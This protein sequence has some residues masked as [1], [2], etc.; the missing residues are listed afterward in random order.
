MIHSSNTLTGHFIRYTLLVKG[1]TPFTYLPTFTLNKPFL[2]KFGPSWHVDIMQVL[3]ICWLLIC[4]EN[5]PVAP[6]PKGAP[7]DWVLV[8]GDRW[9]TSL[10][11][12]ELCEMLNCPAGSSHQKRVHCGH[13]GMDMVGNSLP[14][15]IPLYHRCLKSS[16]QPVWH[17]QL[18]HVQ[19]HLYP[20]SSPFCCSVLPSASCLEHVFMPKS[21]ELGPCDY[22]ISCLC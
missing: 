1:W 5:L 7:V 17:Q 20:L 16:D 3:Q 10:R 15:K 8:T 9:S 2:R 14:V 19:R 18:C 22:L 4:D 12:Y 6:H 21:T 11:W 13:K